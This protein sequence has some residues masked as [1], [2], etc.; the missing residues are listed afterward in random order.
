M[1]RKLI[2]FVSVGTLVLTLAIPTNLLAAQGPMTLAFDELYPPGSTAR[3]KVIGIRDGALNAKDS[4]AYSLSKTGREVKTGLSNVRDYAGK[5]TS[6]V[7]RS[8]HDGLYNTKD[9]VTTKARIT[10]RNVKRGYQN[11]KD[12]VS[13]TYKTNKRSFFSRFKPKSTLNTAKVNALNTVDK[14]AYS[15]TKGYRGVRDGA[16]NTYDKSSLWLKKT[17]RS[18][19]STTLNKS[20]RCWISCQF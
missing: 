2:N 14:T 19:R 10:S 16:L 3:A 18:I 5:T 13:L 15:V 1:L 4:A 11:T 6:K 17:G 8:V 7:S 9:G 12:A 20:R